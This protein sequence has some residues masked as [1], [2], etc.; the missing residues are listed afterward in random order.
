LT[1]LGLSISAHWALAADTL[2]EVNGEPITAEQVEKAIGAPLAKLQEQIYNLKRQKLEALIAERLLA[3]AASK[4]GISVP[5]LL[6][7]EVTAK[8]GLVTEQEIES[9]YQ[10]NKAQLKGEEAALREQIRAHLQNQKLAAQREAFLRSLRS[11]AKI[12]VHLQPPPVLR[13]EVA[14]N[15][16]PFKGAV[17]AAVTIVKFEDFHCPFCKKVQQTL[18]QLLSRYSKEVKVVHRDFP[19]DNLHPQARKAH[20][21]ARCA[22][23]QGKFWS[24]HDKLYANAPK[25]SLEDLN[26]YAKEVRLNLVAFEQCLNKGKYQAAVQK[27]VEEGTRIG[28]TGTPAFFINGRMISGAQPLE[29][30]VRIIEEEL[31]QR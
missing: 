4:R 7:A 26:T 22:N 21:A 9:F 11:K 28:V 14:V 8:I 29:S 19:I 15:G 17:K 6:D 5:A 25:A 24:Y 12:L 18:A 2:A 10:A 27:D 16:A 31:A 23:E 30:F 13:S 20:E 1:T 3:K